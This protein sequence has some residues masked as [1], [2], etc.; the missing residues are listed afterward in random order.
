MHFKPISASW[1]NM[2]ERFFCDIKTEGLCC[3]MFTSVLELM[4]VIDECITHHNINSKPFVWT[5]TA[6][7]ILQKVIRANSQLERNTTL[8]PEN[9]I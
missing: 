5:K 9:A 8:A 2:V 6:H 1:L 3:D 7:N 4:S